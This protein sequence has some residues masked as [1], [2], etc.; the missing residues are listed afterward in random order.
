MW[1]KWW[2]WREWKE[3]IVKNEIR[4]KQILSIGKILYGLT[5]DGRVYWHGYFNN[6]QVWM[7][8]SMI[9]KEES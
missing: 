8:F 2:K 7:K 6:E 3:D 4:F 9:V 5:E 1:W